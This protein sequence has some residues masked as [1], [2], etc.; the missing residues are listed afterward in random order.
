MNQLALLALFGGAATASVVYN[1]LDDPRCHVEPHRPILNPTPSPT[2]IQPPTHMRVVYTGTPAPTERPECPGLVSGLQIVDLANPDAPPTVLQNGATVP[3]SQMPATFT[4][5]AITEGEDVTRVKFFLDGSHVHTDSSAPFY[6]G[7]DYEPA[8]LNVEGTYEISAVA[9]TADGTWESS[10]DACSM[11]ITI[12]YANPPAVCEGLVTKFALFDTAAQAVV[13]GYESLADGQT[14]DLREL[15]DHLSLIVLNNGRGTDQVSFWVGSETT[16]FAEVSG[17]PLAITGLSGNGDVPEWTTL[18]ETGTYTIQA[19]MVD[20]LGNL[21]RGVCEIT[22]HVDSDW[23]CNYEIEGFSLIN[24]VTNEVIPG[25]E[26]MAGYRVIDLAELPTD[27]LSIRANKRNE[28][29]RGVKFYKNADNWRQENKAPYAWN[30]DKPNGNYNAHKDFRIPGTVLQ[31]GARGRVSNGWEDRENMCELSLSITD[32]SGPPPISIPPETIIRVIEVD[33][34]P[35]APQLITPIT[36]GQQMFLDSPVKVESV[37]TN[38][39]VKFKVFNYI[40]DVPMDWITTAFVTPSGVEVCD[41][42]E[43]VAFEDF[44][45]HVYEAKCHEGYAFA[46]VFAYST[47]FSTDQTADTSSLPVE[48]RNNFDGQVVRYTFVFSCD[49]ENN[50]D[51]PDEIVGGVPVEYSRCTGDV[52]NVWGDPHVVPY[53]G[54]QW[55]CQ[56][57]GEFVI[58]KVE[59]NNYDFDFEARGRFSNFGN[60]GLKWTFNTGLA[61]KQDVSIQLNIAESAGPYSTMFEDLPLNFFV[62]GESRLLTQGSGDHRV[63]VTVNRFD[64]NIFF[65]T[66]GISVQVNVRPESVSPHIVVIPGSLATFVCLPD[67]NPNF[68]AVTGLLGTPNKDQA[69]DWMDINGNTIPFNDHV[70]YEYCATNWCIR[71]ANDSFFVHDEAGYDF[72]YYYGC[73][74]PEPNRRRELSLIDEASDKIKSL[75]AQVGMNEQCLFDGVN[76]GINAAEAAVE[77]LK[78]LEKKRIETLTS[79]FQDDAACC[80]RDFKTCDTSCAADKYK[81]G[82]CDSND[83]FTWLP[84][85]T[86][87]DDFGDLEHCVPKATTCTASSSCCPGLECQAGVCAPKADDSVARRLQEFVFVRPDIDPFNRNIIAFS[88]L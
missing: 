16:P 57:D 47:T 34:G 64:I 71:D 87:D 15:P 6:L 46:D 83:T 50:P 5:Q 26:H 25:Y 18:R 61:I 67:D 24:A 52:G 81:C 28:N 4:I 41:K 29:W 51:I 88:E 33:D 23:V 78:A 72:D 77:N 82:E 65:V 79:T 31:I 62:N 12:D 60:E 84:H 36:D 38:E 49:C 63:T 19:R 44:T 80:S 27:L 32:S 59:L 37:L 30:G 73:D 70:E 85:G 39:T 58:T 45:E 69:D 42:V 13:P 20:R 11:E 86:Y 76:G 40:K 14:L 54:G 8:Q 10:D 55:G 66:T 22:L 17:S 43:N 74:D 53:D 3:L 35:C 1:D 7:G 9:A 56:A 75:C 68:G 2:P 21:E 48:C